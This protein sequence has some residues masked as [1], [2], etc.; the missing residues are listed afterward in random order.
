MQVLNKAL[1][2]SHLLMSHWPKQVSVE[3]VNTGQLGVLGATNPKCLEDLTN[4][5]CEERREVICGEFELGR[6]EKL[7]DHS[8]EEKK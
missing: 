8:L 6:L 3:A 1:L 7:W 5:V 4:T 2:V